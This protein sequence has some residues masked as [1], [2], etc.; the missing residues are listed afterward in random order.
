MLYS[1]FFPSPIPVSPAFGAF[2]NKNFL[3]HIVRES[4]L[5][6]AF[7]MITWFDHSGSVNAVHVYFCC[8]KKIPAFSVELFI[9]DVSIG[10]VEP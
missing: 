1:A 4:L 10:L 8:K 9:S 7:G 6:P 5:R 3:A 2:D